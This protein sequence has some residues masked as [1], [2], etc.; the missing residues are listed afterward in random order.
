M[1]G[2]PS[3]FD[4]LTSVDATGLNPPKSIEEC[5]GGIIPAHGKLR[6]L[7]QAS[8]KTRWLLRR[9]R[10]RH[11]AVIRHRRVLRITNG[12]RSFR[13]ADDPESLTIL[14]RRRQAD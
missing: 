4:I 8:E 5:Y 7:K 2:S 11:H 12:E 14:Y 13:R 10:S 3:I 1:S 6:G 9:H